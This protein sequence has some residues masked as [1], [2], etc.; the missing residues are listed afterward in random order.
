[1][2]SPLAQVELFALCLCIIQ[3]FY[4]C[5]FAKQ[6]NYSNVFLFKN[7]FLRMSFFVFPGSRIKVPGERMVVNGCGVGPGIHVNT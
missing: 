4:K 5:L 3:H 6:Y 1:M 7:T 2:S